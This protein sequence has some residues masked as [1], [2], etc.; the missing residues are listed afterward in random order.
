MKCSA[1]I[2]ICGTAL[3]VGCSARYTVHNVGGESYA[4]LDR[5]RVIFVVVPKDGS[6]GTN[7]YSGSG[8]IVAQSVAA[9]FSRYA[10]RIQ[11]AEKSMDAATAQQ[12]ARESGAAYLVIPVISQ[13]E[14]RAT[15]WSGRPSKM[16]IRLAIVDPQGGTQLAAGSIEGR[17][18]IVS[19]TSTSPESL[20][21][22][23]LEQYVNTLFP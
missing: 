21:K 18:R 7:T 5:G 13:W 1:L 16:S 3:I 2:A 22:E 8:Q 9:A 10:S 17:S 15:E 6:Y 20:L 4:K 11:I 19:L 14:Q 12:A 23:P